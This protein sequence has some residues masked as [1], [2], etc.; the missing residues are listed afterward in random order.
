MADFAEGLR[1]YLALSGSSS[2]SRF[3]CYGLS[4][5]SLLVFIGRVSPLTAFVYRKKC[6]K[7]GPLVPS[8]R[9]WRLS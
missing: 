8:A 3:F 6:G 7:A 9:F 4:I 5:F 1:K 2:F